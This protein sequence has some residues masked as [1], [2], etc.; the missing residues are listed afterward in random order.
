MIKFIYFLHFI[1]CCICFCHMFIKVAYLLTYLNL[2]Y[3]NDKYFQEDLELI[4]I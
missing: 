2:D 3:C 1:L 4:T